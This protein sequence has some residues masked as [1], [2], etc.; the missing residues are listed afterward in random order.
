M[1]TAAATVVSET[2]TDTK[3]NSLARLRAKVGCRGRI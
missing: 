2:L 1:T 3:E